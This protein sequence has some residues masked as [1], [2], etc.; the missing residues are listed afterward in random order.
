[1]KRIEKCQDI[2]EGDDCTLDRVLRQS[3]FGLG[4]P[5]GIP[6][7]SDALSDGYHTVKFFHSDDGDCIYGNINCFPSS[8]RIRTTT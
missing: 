8:S 7:V 6:T 4:T 2:I 3:E 1:M 5:N